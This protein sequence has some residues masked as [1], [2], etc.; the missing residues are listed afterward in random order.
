MI[1][2]KLVVQNQL[3]LRPLISILSKK[4][5][6]T[7]FVIYSSFYI[8]ISCIFYTLSKAFPNVIILNS[9]IEFSSLREKIF[10]VI[11]FAPLIETLFIQFII[12]E[13]LSVLLPKQ[14]FLTC[15]VSSTIFSLNHLF[16]VLYIFFTFFAGFILAIAFFS[17]GKGRRGFILVFCIHA[18][19][20]CFALIINHLILPLYN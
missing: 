19:Y 2:C 17:S 9:N 11:L 8:L 5:I 10:I 16:S 6:V 7:Q 13:I 4:K 12:I 3:F 1:N 14:I 20:N 15:L 18:F